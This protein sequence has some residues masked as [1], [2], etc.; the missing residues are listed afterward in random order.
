MILHSNRKSTII[1][2]AVI[3]MTAVIICYALVDP[4]SRYMPHCMFRMLTGYDCPGCGAQRCMHAL[5]HGQVAKAWSYNPAMF[6]L[7]PLLAAYGAIELGGWR[8]RCLERWLYSR[9]MIYI[10]AT[11]IVLWWILR[12]VIWH[13][14]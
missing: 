9:A 11:A 8:N 14:Q 7:M 3:V 13:A 10:L 2:T 5:L 6:V 4:E 12:N 1:M